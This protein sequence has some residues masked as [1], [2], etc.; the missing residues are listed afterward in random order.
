MKKLSIVVPYRDREEHL[1]QFIPFMEEILTKSEG[2]SA[3]IVIVEQDGD[4]PFNRAKLLN[5]GYKE[6]EGSDYFC[7]HDVDM[8]PLN[9]DYSP[10]EAPTHLAAEVEQFNWGLAYEGY[11]GGVTMFDKESFERI[12]GYANEYWGWGAED[13]DVLSRCLI[14]GIGVFRKPCKYRS[15]AHGRAIDNDLYGKNLQKLHNFKIKPNQESIMKDGL[16]TLKYEKNGE[17]KIGSISRKI[18]VSI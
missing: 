2:Y 12:N 8:L 14:M 3:E 9:P 16:N 15:L 17:E 7:F 11:F 4:K 1:S 18:K 10:V 5:I 13:D 6:S